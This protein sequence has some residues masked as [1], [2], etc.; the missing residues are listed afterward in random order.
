MLEALKRQ[1]AIHNTSELLRRL[2]V[3]ADEDPFRKRVRK[4]L[5]QLVFAL[6]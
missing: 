3:L 6:A 5:G 4:A 2:L 1:A